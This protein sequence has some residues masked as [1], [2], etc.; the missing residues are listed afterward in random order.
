MFYFKKITLVAAI[1]LGAH[2]MYSQ[3]AEETAS[4]S[5]VQNSTTAVNHQGTVKGE[6]YYLFN[7]NRYVPQNNV[8]AWV[9]STAVM[10]S[11]DGSFQVIFKSMPRVSKKYIVKA[12]GTFY[13]EGQE[14]EASIALL[15]D[16][17]D[18]QFWS[19]A[20]NSGKIQVKIKGNKVVVMVKNVKI[21]SSEGNNCKTITGQ[22]ILDQE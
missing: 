14:G 19:V 15:T 21:C 22:I 3:S 11:V 7:G 1:C 12:Y 13:N 4:Q 16:S 5:Y 2:G 20:P 18:H 17:Y 8:I 10:N 9:S 6:S